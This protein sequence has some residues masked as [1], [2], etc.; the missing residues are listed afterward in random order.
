M[1]DFPWPS[2]VA[3]RRRRLVQVL[4]PYWET[5]EAL[6][7]FVVTAPPDG[8]VRPL[9]GRIDLI[10]PGD[11][12]QLPD[13]QA[14]GHVRVL[15]E[16]LPGRTFRDRF[17]AV[18]DGK[19]LA[20][21]QVAVLP[22]GLTVPWDACKR[23]SADYQGGDDWGLPW[24]CWNFVTDRLPGR[25]ADPSGPLYGHGGRYYSNFD[26]LL[27]QVSGFQPYFGHSDARRDRL[28]LFVW[29]YR[30]RLVSANQQGTALY[31]RM[32]GENL[33]DL[34]VVGKVK[35]RGAREEQF[36][37]PAAAEVVL[38]DLADAVQVECSLVC[39]E[40][41]VDQAWLGVVEQPL[42]GS[43]AAALAPF[44]ASGVGHV[45]LPGTQPPEGNL[46]EIP[47]RGSDRDKKLQVFVSSTYEDLH[48]EREALTW[49]ILSVRHIPAGMENFGAYPDQSWKV[50][51]E[52]IDD[53][54]VYVL[55]IAGRY[56]SVD[57]E[58][59]LSWTEKEYD[60][61]VQRN[62]PVL[63]FLRDEKRIKL[64]K[65]PAKLKEG[66]EAKQKLA[67]FRKKVQAYQTSTWT[68][69]E[70][71]SEKVVGALYR[72]D[73]RRDRVLRGWVRGST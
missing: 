16:R 4:E 15:A 40:D 33:S 65:L 61:A 17:V 13:P 1:L 34:S 41:Q 47:L 48:R 49:A 51:T 27:S 25:P 8:P 9:F 63:A 18:L 55:V 3:E 54:D 26:D 45:G 10:K 50:I 58:T 23:T 60:Y 42:V 56:G 35:R 24:P 7:R 22:E 5:T 29:D 72:L 6:V 44:G 59:G 64:G 2:S 71:L 39:G 43:G 31:L 67:L 37:R 38:K 69:K 73:R 70:D 28:S 30:G 53:S 20:V 66:R 57:P 12:L 32:E 36:E 21:G 68:T 19:P 52:T 46:G 14:L 11:S 62:L